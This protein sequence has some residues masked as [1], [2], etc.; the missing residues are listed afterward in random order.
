MLLSLADSDGDGF[1]S[2]EETVLSA[3]IFREVD[4]DG[5]G[6]LSSLEFVDAGIQ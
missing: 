4:K 1:V 3:E 2:F 6:K 5:D